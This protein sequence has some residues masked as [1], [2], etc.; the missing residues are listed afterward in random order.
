MKKSQRSELSYERRKESYME[1]DEKTS[2]RNN[3]PYRVILQRMQSTRDPAA[4]TISQSQPHMISL[5]IWLKQGNHSL[6]SQNYAMPTNRKLQKWPKTRI[7]WII[8]ANYVEIWN[9]TRRHTFQA[10]CR[11]QLPKSENQIAVTYTLAIKPKG[12]KEERYE[13]QYVSRDSL[14]IMKDCLVDSTTSI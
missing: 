12:N 6:D 4:I 7:S 10:V 5:D 11:A 8:E 3:F 13:A 9:R 1:S 14:D 2:N